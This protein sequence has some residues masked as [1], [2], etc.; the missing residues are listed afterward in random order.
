VL[1]SP[2]AVAPEA[3]WLPG[4]TFVAENFR[5]PFEYT[6]PDGIQLNPTTASSTMYALTEGSSKTYPGL[7]ITPVENTRGI[8]VAF[9]RD[10]RTHSDLMNSPDITLRPDSFFDDLRKNPSLDVRPAAATLVSGL[11]AE[12]A[13]VRAQIS[14][15]GAYQDIHLEG[16]ADNSLL[17]LVIGFPGTLTVIRADGGVLIVH[18]WAADADQFDAWL[19]IAR[20]IVGSIKFL[21]TP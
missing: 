6:V 21:D 8:T 1:A 12:E 3:S 18:V 16:Q 4:E 11:P 19:P 15:P 5:S 7:G 2:S 9:T 20:S 14:G 17:V 10:A 13:E